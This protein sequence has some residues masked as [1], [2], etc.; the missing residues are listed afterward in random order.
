M[1]HQ[2]FT[3]VLR[4][5][6]FALQPKCPAQGFT[7]CTR[8]EQHRTVKREA[9]TSGADVFSSADSL[10]LPPAGKTSPSTKNFFPQQPTL[11]PGALRRSKEW[12][13]AAKPP[14]ISSPWVRWMKSQ[15]CRFTWEAINNLL[16][17]VTSSHVRAVKGCQ[18]RSCWVCKSFH[19]L[20]NPG[21]RCAPACSTEGVLEEEILPQGL[22][23]CWGNKANRSLRRA[24]SNH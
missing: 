20:W 18:E 7:S 11:L 10:L 4:V 17:T 12:G 15:G 23:N 3:A 13:S 2:V 19:V 8:E 5:D 1:E 9:L 14:S 16:S 24:A 22:S 21:C 6:G